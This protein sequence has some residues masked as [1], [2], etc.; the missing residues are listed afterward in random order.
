[1]KIEKGNAFKLKNKYYIEKRGQ[2]LLRTGCA[3]PTT[4]WGVARLSQPRSDSFAGSFLR[5]PAWPRQAVCPCP[6]F[7]PLL[8]SFTHCSLFFRVKPET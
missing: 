5:D 6:C 8:P 7:P 2:G 3:T 4:Q 1:M